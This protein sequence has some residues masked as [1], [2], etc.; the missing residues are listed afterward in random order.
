MGFDVS[1]KKEMKQTKERRKCSY[2][3]GIIPVTITVIL[4]VA[5]ILLYE[6]KWKETSVVISHSPSKLH[7]IE[8]VEVGRAWDGRPSS[9]R[10]KS[11]GDHM[12]FSIYNNGEK[13]DEFNVVVYWKNDYEAIITLYGY[14]QMPETFHFIAPLNKYEA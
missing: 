13:L 8:V 2:L 7:T 14:E 3:S 5:I 10:I 11:E 9:V 6:M 1:I 4:L 12:D